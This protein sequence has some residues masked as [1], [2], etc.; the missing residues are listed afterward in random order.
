MKQSFYKR[1]RC[2]SRNRFSL[3]LLV[4]FSPI[5]LCFPCVSNANDMFNVYKLMDIPSYHPS[6]SPQKQDVTQSQPENH[7]VSDANSINLFTQTGKASLN[8]LN[9]IQER[10]LTIHTGKQ[11]KIQA[12]YNDGIYGIAYIQNW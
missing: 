7:P 6:L 4:I 1:M 2:A 3:F 11:E 9:S 5:T 8:P 12:V 10:Y